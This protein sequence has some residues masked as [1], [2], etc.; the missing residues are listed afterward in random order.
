[1]KAHIATAIAEGLRSKNIEVWTAIQG[2]IV[3]LDDPDILRHCLAETR[4]LVTN[5]DDFLRLNRT[6]A[7]HAGIAY[8]PQQTKSIGQ[9]IEGLVLVYEVYDEAEQMLGRVE[10]I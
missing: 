3:G 5:D 8:W 10:F 7:P 6:G 4:V 2:G 9:I 1:M